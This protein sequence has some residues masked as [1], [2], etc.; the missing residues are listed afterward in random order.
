M[1]VKYKV[2]EEKI[3]KER[4]KYGLSLNE[5]VDATGL[6]NSIIS[7]VKNGKLFLL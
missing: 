7:L 3:K 1:R 2:V 6:S 4:I 5:L